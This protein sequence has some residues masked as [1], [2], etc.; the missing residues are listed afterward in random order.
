MSLTN[1]TVTSLTFTGVNITSAATVQT[2]TATGNGRATIILRLIGVAGNGNYIAY[3]ARTRGANTTIVLPKTTAAAAS[4]ETKIEFD[5]LDVG[6]L[7]GDALAFVVDGL[8]GDT[9]VSG[10]VDVIAYNFSLLEAADNIGINWADVAN[11][12]S[13]VALT[14][15][16]INTAGLTAR[17]AIT[18]SDAEQVAAGN[19]SMRSHYSDAVD[20]DTDITDDLANAVIWLAV[21]SNKF[22]TDDKSLFFV[23]TT[24]GLLYINGAAPATP[25]EATDASIV[26]TGSSGDWTITVTWNSRASAVLDGIEGA[27]WFGI[28]YSLGA[29]DKAVTE[30]TASL[31][32][33]GIQAV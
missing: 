7:S 28:K 14:N 19:L 24:D 9:S 31:N 23:K 8:A 3:I 10:T 32:Q 12:T 25:A 5:S 29:N 16:T 1:P 2:Y 15:T 21:K 30:G 33:G 26:V 13:T 17:L 27:F 20:F 18:T 6:F 4:G 11:P 22:D